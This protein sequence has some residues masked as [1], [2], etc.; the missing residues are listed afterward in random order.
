MPPAE[1]RWW[2]VSDLV[3]IVS[4]ARGNWMSYP[5]L[6]HGADRRV[7]MST[8]ATPSERAHLPAPPRSGDR[9]RTRTSLLTA[10][11]MSVLGRL[12]TREP[13]VGRRRKTKTEA[14]IRRQWVDAAWLSTMTLM[15][16]SL[17]SYFVFAVGHLPNQR[18]L[19]DWW[20]WAGEYDSS[21][22]PGGT[23]GIV[24]SLTLALFIAI[25]LN[26]SSS[27][28]TKVTQDAAELVGIELL[29]LVICV[30][31]A[32]A[33]W[34]LLPSSTQAPGA[35]GIG[36]AFTL[37]GLAYIFCL[38]LV[39]SQ[40]SNTIQVY[41]AEVALSLAIAAT[42]ALRSLHQAVDQIP[43]S[44]LNPAR[45]RTTVCLM[46]GSVG[47]ALGV[48]ASLAYP[49]ILLASGQAVGVI[50]WA[51]V[52]AFCAASTVASVAFVSVIVPWRATARL[53]REPTD[54]VILQFLRW[55][56]W[57]LVAVVMTITVAAN[58]VAAGV[59]TG[60]S[61]FSPPLLLW[62]AKRARYSNLWTILTYRAV[63]RIRQRNIKSLREHASVYTPT[64]IRS[65]SSMRATS[66]PD[67]I[68]VLAQFSATDD[69]YQGW[70]Q[71]DRFTSPCPKRQTSAFR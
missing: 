3:V 67:D 5:A 33:A 43:R 40:P 70:N 11:M 20:W 21:W 16:A 54:L 24:A 52:A 69:R 32:T 31:A 1:H 4:S 38:L 44:Y 57:P 7:V 58:S 42:A 9:E 66:E 12:P 59:A 47:L 51:K 41:R 17:L 13:N 36:A 27:R 60:I 61:Q 49:A 30:T 71:S 26:R 19:V 37:A 53:T 22:A 48:L 18:S 6:P 63:R 50:Q 25:A 8:A 55:I 45:R 23:L 35:T 62:V 68:S 65:I 15:F 29:V 14:A 46:I 10:E 39:T 64:A 2:G 56:I 34:L 28:T